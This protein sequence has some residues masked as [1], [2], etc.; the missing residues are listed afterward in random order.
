LFK[1]ISYFNYNIFFVLADWEKKNT[2]Q[3][4]QSRNGSIMAI[5]EDIISLWCVFFYLTG[6]KK[7]LELIG[8]EW[9]IIE[10]DP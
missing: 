10:T 3:W 9:Y 5:G 8:I 2:M 6:K 1:I 4:N 7:V